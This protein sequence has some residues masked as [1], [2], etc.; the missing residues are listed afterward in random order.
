MPGPLNLLATMITTTTYGTWLPGDARGYVEQGRV[1][2]GDPFRAGES[3]RTMRSGAVYLSE[4]EQDAALHGLVA[5][6]KE[7]EY[8]LLT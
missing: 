1:L 7:F 3:E 4:D 5:A 8:R 2:P 6:C